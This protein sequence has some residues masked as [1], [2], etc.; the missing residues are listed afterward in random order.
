MSRCCICRCFQKPFA[1]FERVS[2]PAPGVKN[3]L[4]ITTAKVPI[5]KFYHIQTS[6][7]GDISLYNTLV[8]LFLLLFWH[9]S[10]FKIAFVF[11][12]NT[13]LS[14]FRLCTTRIFWRHM[15]P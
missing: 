4:P 10:L 8:E 14:P 11:L 2:T 3:V 7:E 13:T 9:F 5:V 1:A 6:L 15:L 12:L